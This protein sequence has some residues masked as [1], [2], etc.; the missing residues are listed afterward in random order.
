MVVPTA[1][2]D[3]GGRAAYQVADVADLAQVD[4]IAA[5]AVEIFGGFDSWVNDA[6]AFIY[7]HMTDVSLED[8]RRLFDATY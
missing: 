6:S 1:I 7:G 2:R 8:Q 4:A 5:K 3:H